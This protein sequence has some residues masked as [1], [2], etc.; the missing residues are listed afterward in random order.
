MENTPYNKSKANVA[1]VGIGYWGKNLVRNFH[2]LGALAALC[3]ADG[4]VEANEAH[5]YAG[6]KFYRDF[7]DVL[8]D[9]SVTAVVLATPAVSHYEMAKAA[10]EA[11]KNILVE[12]PLAVDVQHGEDLV[13]LASA[14]DKIL[15]VGHILRYHPAI[16]KLQQLIHD[17]TL[18]KINYLYSN[19]LNIGKIRTEENILWSFAPHDI[20]AMLALLNEMPTRVTCTGG[21]CLNHDV[22]DVTLSHFDFPSGVQAHIFVSWLHPVKEQRLVVV[23]SEKMAVFDDTAEHK[24]VLYPHKVAWP[25]RVPTAVKAAGEIVDL[26]ECEPLRAECRHFLD[27]IASGTSPVSN[28]AEGLRVL[29]VLDACQRALLNETVDLAHSDARNQK[30]ERPYFVHESAYVDEGAE[31]GAGTKIWHFSH[32]MKAARIGARC[33]IGQNVNVDGG[34]LIGDNVKIQNNVSIYTGAVIE[35]DVFL[36]PSCVLTN[37]TNP[38]SQVNRHSLYETTHLQR[39]CTIGAN[40][41]IVCGVTIGRYAFVGAGAVVTKSFP[42]F[43][44]VVG[45]PARQVGWISRHGH[46]VGSPDSSGVMLCPESGYR[47]E[48]VEPGVLRCLDLDEEAPLPEEFSFG[49]KSYRQLKEELNYEGSASRS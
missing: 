8:S 14:K 26:E 23:G 40:A 33:V 9:S 22:F 31:I 5:K 1:V 12:K 30:K 34:T 17:G 49:T 47:Y 2:D 21:A 36:G 32:V 24:L 43:A 42:D 20:S 48:E 15:M 6:V 46:R 18:G 38:R 41:T 39:G 35:D 29:K 11:G 45:N 27:C 37:V 28:G 10:L 25:N 16:L 4:S 44:L 19:R 7:S 13:R 3:D